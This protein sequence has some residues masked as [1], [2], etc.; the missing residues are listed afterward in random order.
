MILEDI[1]QIEYNKINCRGC[2]GVFSADLVAF[3]LGKVFKRALSEM[4]RDAE[5]E[6]GMWE[7]LIRRD[8]RFYYT[9]R[10]LCQELGYRLDKEG[11]QKITLRVKDVKKQLEFLTNGIPFQEIQKGNRD[12]EIYNYLYEA[13]QPDYGSPDEK[14]GQIEMLIH[15]LAKCNDEEKILTVKINVILGMDVN[16][17]E[18]P[19]FLKYMAEGRTWKT[20]TRV[21]PY[22][23]MHL[24]SA[25]GYRKEII[26]G[27]AGLARVGKTVFIAS[28]IHQ[29]KKLT[30]G[31]FISIKKS[32]SS[33]L[34]KFQKDII[35]EYEKGES[36]RKTEV[37]N[38]EE[39][40]D[41]YVPVRIGNKEYNFIFVD[42]PGE[43]YSGKSDESLNFISNKKPILQKADA[44]W[45]FIDP[46]MINPDY[47]NMHIQRKEDA[48]SQLSSIIKVVG[49]IYTRKIPAAVIV[50]QSDQ[51]PAEYG[52]YRPNTN[53]MEQYLLNG[54]LDFEEMQNF[55]KATDGFVDKMSNFQ[56]SI[57]NIF[58]GFSMF[59]VASY[60]FDITDR[61][62]LSEKVIRP[63]MVELPFL[64]TLAK[65]RVLKTARV[66]TSKTKFGKEKTEVKQMEDLD[67]LYMHK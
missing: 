15:N 50:T 25:V 24:D 32:D 59:A 10:D 39:I 46:A 19:M 5:L 63:S 51:I 57:E 23:G 26:I 36:I 43:I 42:M 65:L 16:G 18:I 6:E 1:K 31:D 11:A 47:A 9:L 44:I 27:L 20:L 8:F 58:E 37:E 2:G 28:L 56:L 7:P 62:I 61:A 66:T 17:N 30:T 38:V 13:V 67:K 64:W 60:G 22:C 53:V 54:A 40:E 4:R 49:K 14:M 52:L 35:D 29:L 3:D 34:E 45:L 12:T 48:N 33:S 41:I 21:C 55:S